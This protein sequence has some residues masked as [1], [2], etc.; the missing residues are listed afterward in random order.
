MKRN[1]VFSHWHDVAD[2]K[3]IDGD[4]DICVHDNNCAPFSTNKRL[5]V[6][7]CRHS[8]SLN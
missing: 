6:M 8:T 7:D 4:D 5:L 3:C 2:N 1:I